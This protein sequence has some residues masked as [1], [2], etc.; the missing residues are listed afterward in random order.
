VGNGNVACCLFSY[1]ATQTL[2]PSHWRHPLIIP[3]IPIIPIFA[4]A[5]AAKSTTAAITSRPIC[6][7]SHHKQQNLP[8]QLLVPAFLGRFLLLSAMLF[9]LIF[10]SFFFKWT[11]SVRYAVVFCCQ[12]QITLR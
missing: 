6:H 3:I 12:M 11:K 7:R 10:I 4:P 5:T 1:C 8:P 9:F 2:G